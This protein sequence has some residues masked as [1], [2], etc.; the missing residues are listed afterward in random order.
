MAVAGRTGRSWLAPLGAT[1]LLFA[2]A[3]WEAGLSAGAAQFARGDL[4]RIDPLEVSDTT[5]D[6]DAGF[7]PAHRH[8]I[9]LP[10]STAALSLALPSLL[11]VR[12]AE[13]QRVVAARP[14]LRVAPKTSPP[15]RA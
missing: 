7:D 10:P 8:S 3:M 12:L 9:A 11:G 2:V 15:P 14:P 1:G 13:T 4:A 5:L 6:G